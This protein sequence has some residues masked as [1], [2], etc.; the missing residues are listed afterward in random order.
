MVKD[1]SGDVGVDPRRLQF[2]NSQSEPFSTL[3]PVP[4]GTFQP[5]G[6]DEHVT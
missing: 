6:N 3:E 4:A 2:L 5:V 1:L